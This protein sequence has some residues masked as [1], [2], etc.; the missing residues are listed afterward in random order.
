PKG[1][2]AIRGK[3]GPEPWDK[4][5]KGAGARG[6]AQLAKTEKF[7]LDKIQR[8]EMAG[9]NALI[10]ERRLFKAGLFGKRRKQSRGGIAHWR[11]APHEDNCALC[12]PSRCKISGFKRD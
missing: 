11:G 12:L 3:V 6:M 10:T 7:G 4:L 5:R 9:R 2:G 1:I 8:T